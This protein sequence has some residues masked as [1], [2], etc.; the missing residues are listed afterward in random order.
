M[1]FE[2]DQS[3]RN[4]DHRQQEHKNGNAI[5]AMHIAHPFA[6]RCIRVSF[7]DVEIF[8]YLTPDSHRNHL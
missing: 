3:N 8:C 2:K 6:M 5:D 7:F 1:F 4:D